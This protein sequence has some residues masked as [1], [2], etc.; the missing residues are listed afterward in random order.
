MHSSRR[1]YRGPLFLTKSIFQVCSCIL[2]RKPST[3]L[4]TIYALLFLFLVSSCD[5]Q[6][7]SKS[8]LHPPIEG[9]WKLMTGTLIEKADTTVTDYTHDKEFIKIINPTH[10][11]FLLHD[12]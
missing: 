4:R 7:S 10:F 12:L 3:M 9:T 5:N 2:P 6:D 11:A 1:S 8:S